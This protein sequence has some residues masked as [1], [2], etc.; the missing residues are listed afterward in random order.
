MLSGYG[1]TMTQYTVLLP[2]SREGGMSGAQLARAS[3]VTQQTMATVLNGLQNKDLTMRQPSPVHAKVM[4]ATPTEQ[5][6]QLL[7]RAYQEVIVQERATAILTQQTPRA[8]TQPAT[9]ARQHSGN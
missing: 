9:S 1:L 7:D 2:L 5:G 3:G 4:I 6:R 8:D